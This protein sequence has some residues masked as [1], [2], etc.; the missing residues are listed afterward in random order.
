MKKEVEEC[1]TNTQNQISVLMW[2]I[3]IFITLCLLGFGWLSKEIHKNE[4]LIIENLK[5]LVHIEASL[6]KISNGINGR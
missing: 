4:E 5:R 2:A 6:N 3:G 1:K